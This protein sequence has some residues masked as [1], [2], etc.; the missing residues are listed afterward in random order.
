MPADGYANYHYDLRTR[1]TT[2]HELAANLNGSVALALEN[3]RIPTHYVR[4]LS[5]DVF[6]WALGKA[7]QDIQYSNLNCVLARFDIEDGVATSRLLAA[8]GPGL[9][10]EGK[11]TLDL[12]E[13]TIDAVFL[14]KQ[15]QKVFSRIAPVELSGD[16]RSPV[17]AAIPAKEAITSIGTLVLVPYVA[18]PVKL[19]EKLWGSVEDRD[20]HGGGC[21]SLKAA[22]EAEAAMQ[23]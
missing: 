20:A 12:G 17:V 16:M 9:A 13:E 23:Q 5:V 6:G 7:A 3:L 21:T 1:G 4:A 15:K 19:F 8:D 14:P 2:P 18:I 10:V 11:M 22:K